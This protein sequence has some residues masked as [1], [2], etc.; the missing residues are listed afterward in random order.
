MINKWI[1][2]SFIYLIIVGLLGIFLRMLFFSPIEGINYR[3]LLHAHSHVAF[4]GWVFNALFAGLLLAYIPDKTKQYRLLFWLLQIAVIGMLVTFPIQGY[5]AASITFTSLHVFLSW[6]FAVKFIKGVGKHD[7]TRHRL[8]LSFVKWSLFFMIFSSIGPFA[9]GFIM[10]KDL[11]GPVANLAIYFYLH[12]QY[13]GWFTFAV[14]GL[15]FWFV[16]KHNLL[17]PSYYTRRFLIFLAAACLPAY[18]LSTLWVHPPSWV[19]AIAMIAATLQLFALAYLLFIVKKL[20]KALKPILTKRTRQLFV[21]ALFAFSTKIVLQFAS[22]FPAIADMAYTVRSFT[23][24]YLHI[25]FLGFVTV[26]LIGWFAQVQLI[27][28]TR[29]I[30]SVALLLFLSGFVLSE[31]LIF[32]QPVLAMQGIAI[33]YYYETLFAISILMPLGIGLLTYFSFEVKGLEKLKL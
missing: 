2:L 19:Y 6:W 1:R 29:R 27:H 28:L 8:S 32:F 31:L 23:I 5:A 14:F 12:F 22:A 30:I 18:S 20:R 21:F 3:H 7:F 10:A 13:D 25:V 26:F 9:L 17:M 4:L 16:E 33:P 24:G 11:S 15:F